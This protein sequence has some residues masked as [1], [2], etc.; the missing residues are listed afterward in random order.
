MINTYGLGHNVNIFFSLMSS[1]KRQTTESKEGKRKLRR[2]CDEEN[3]DPSS[4]Q[5]SNHAIDP[6][7]EEAE[8]EMEQENQ[9]ER[10]E[11]K[12][13]I[14]LL[15]E[16]NAMVIPPNDEGIPQNIEIPVTSEEEKLAKDKKIFDILLESQQWKDKLLNLKTSSFHLLQ[17]SKTV[18]GSGFG[19]SLDVKM[20]N[21]ACEMCRI[22]SPLKCFICNDVHNFQ[23]TLNRET[24]KVK[25]AC[26]QDETESWGQNNEVLNLSISFL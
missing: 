21:K 4:S 15:D 23:I 2:I 5:L 17:H 10:K 25:I 11:E 6:D 19:P 22:D 16:Y 12:K 3:E 9:R 8:L 18:F 1:K 7:A 20:D 13:N 14:D 26:S 24:A